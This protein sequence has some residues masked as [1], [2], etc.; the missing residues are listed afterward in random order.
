MLLPTRN[1][2]NTTPT[3]SSYSVGAN[4]SAV[5]FDEEIY[6][7]RMQTA[8]SPSPGGVNACGQTD[9]WHH[10]GDPDLRQAMEG[11]APATLTGAFIDKPFGTGRPALVEL[12]FPSEEASQGSTVWS[13]LGRESDH[14][15]GLQGNHP[16]PVSFHAPTPKSPQDSQASQDS[17]GWED[18][19]GRSS[20]STNRGQE[21]SLLREAE[22]PSS[23][24]S[25]HVMQP[26]CM[27]TR[28]VREVDTRKQERGCSSAAVYFSPASRPFP[29][30]SLRTNISVDGEATSAASRSLMSPGPSS[31][32]AVTVTWPQLQRWGRANG[33][34]WQ[35]L[36]AVGGDVDVDVGTSVEARKVLMHMHEG[37]SPGVEDISGGGNQ[38]ESTSSWPY[39]SRT[40]EV[41]APEES[42]SLHEDM[43]D[44]SNFGKAEAI[45]WD[46][47]RLT[48]RHKLPCL[49]E[50]TLGIPFWL[51]Q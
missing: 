12:P 51:P 3:R 31:G 24:D 46:E 29:T 13:A 50:P 15:W 25:A 20:P 10:S 35:S 16:I 7:K 38:L 49:R 8:S 34:R 19:T 43:G 37:Q 30:E 14:V 48:E 9:A 39:G 4:A 1:W 22:K 27:G 5:H 45:S 47:V 11:P 18:W 33:E 44:G 40:A 2:S 21:R 17:Q 42:D 41:T 6:R 36:S 32:E 28:P 26:P 23:S